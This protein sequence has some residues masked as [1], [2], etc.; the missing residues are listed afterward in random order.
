VEANP[1][2]QEA[3]SFLIDFY[4]E[5]PKEPGVLEWGKRA[6]ELGPS[7]SKAWFGY[8]LALFVAGKVSDAKPVFEHCIAITPADASVVKCKQMIKW[9][10]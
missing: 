4:K 10:K 7:D 1:D 9:V 2:G 5:K 3:L 6:T 8:G